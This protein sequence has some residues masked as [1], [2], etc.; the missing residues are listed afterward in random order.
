MAMYAPL[1][2]LALPVTWIVV[3]VA[4][5]M[6]MFRALGVDTWRR[7]LEASGSSLF[8]LGFVQ[9]HDLPTVI[10]GFSEAAIGLGLLALLIA[11]LPTIYG[12][13]S[14]R[15]V[16]VAQ[17][18]VY[19]G[20]PPSAVVML[21]RAH[22][23]GQ[24][25]ELDDVWRTWQVWFSELGETHTSLAVL[26][27][28][29]SP[30][31]DRSWVT[32]AGC[33]LDAAALAQSTLA[34]QWSAQASLCIRSGFLALREIAGFFGVPFD[35]D[36]APDDPISITREEFEAAYDTLASAGVPVRPD[37]QQCWRDF[38]GW[39]VN[40]DQVLLALAGLTMPPYA[41]WSSDR[42]LRYHRPPLRRSR[43]RQPPRSGA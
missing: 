11:Y 27:F 16:P 35:P 40:Y 19:A 30:Q 43:P 23:I 26:N 13:F 24:L 4:G 12:A 2:L 15:E 9:A 3:V 18:A 39:R 8:T 17:L 14:R 10:L 29:R 25:G 7:A 5:Y 41:P 21:T 20:S 32:S 1:S 31:P 37:R 34:I 22:L 6:A 42:S 38:A 33:I 28:F 36:P